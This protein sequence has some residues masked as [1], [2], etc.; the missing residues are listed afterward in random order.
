MN[1]SIL[2]LGWRTL[3]R[4]LRAGELRL[5]AVAVTLPWPH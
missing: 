3:L 5:L 1:F 4:D 2:Q